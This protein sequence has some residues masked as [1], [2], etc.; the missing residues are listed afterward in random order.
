MA[1]H[2][3]ISVGVVSLVCIVILLIR[4]LIVLEK[5]TP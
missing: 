5:G 4:I 1:Y 3:M 2:V